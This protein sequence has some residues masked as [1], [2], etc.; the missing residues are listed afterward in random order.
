MYRRGANDRT[1]ILH[2]IN[3]CTAASPS[4]THQTHTPRIVVATSHDMPGW[5]PHPT[6]AGSPDAAQGCLS[7]LR[8][9]HQ[10]LNMQ[11]ATPGQYPVLTRL[12]T[13]VWALPTQSCPPCPPLTL[14]PQPNPEPPRHTAPP[15][16]LT[17]HIPLVCTRV[18]TLPPKEPTTLT[19]K[20]SLW[21]P[22]RASPVPQ[23]PHPHQ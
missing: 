20:H 10:V 14:P 2:S 4:R 22:Q 16:R 8:P 23:V 17:T 9:P 18:N 6:A 3:A 21:C 11:G 5:R 12:P 13:W 19:H 7:G 15:P 1:P